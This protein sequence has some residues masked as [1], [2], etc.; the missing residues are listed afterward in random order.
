MFRGWARAAVVGLACVGGAWIVHAQDDA[1]VQSCA[2]GPRPTDPNETAFQGVGE[3]ERLSW[4]ADR[5]PVSDD[6]LRAAAAAWAGAPLEIRTVRCAGLAMEGAFR[7]A[8]YPYTRVSA[9]PQRVEAGLVRFQVVEGWV[10][11]VTPA[12]DNAR[13]RLQAHRRLRSLEAGDEPRALPLREVERAAAL[14]DTAPGLVARMAVTRGGEDRAGAIR[15][16]AEAEP[17]PRNIVVNL[18]NFGADE[19]GRTGASILFSTPGRAPLG[20]RLTLSFY[21][22]L[23]L[24]EQRAARIT[25]QRGLTASGLVAGLE[26]AYGQAEPSGEVRVLGAAAESLSG[27]FELT[28]PVRLG[29]TTRLQAGMGVDGADQSG[30]LFGGEVRLSEDSTRNVFARLWGEAAPGCARFTSAPRG[31]CWRLAGEIEARQ[32]LDGL[33]AS[34]EGDELLARPFADPQAHVLRAA[35]DAET[36]SGPLDVRARLQIS[37]QASSAALMA[38]EEFN[39]GNYTLVRGYDPGAVAGDSGIAG[40]LELIGPTLRVRR[41]GFEPFGFYDLGKVWNE[42]PGAPDGRTLASVG[43]GMRMNLDRGVRFEATWSR[44]LHPPL[45]LGESQPS[46]RVLFSLTTSVTSLLRQAT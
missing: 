23:D 7:D 21:T 2:A 31:A 39:F 37:G 28:H 13:A 30:D 12:G 46:S 38:F 45:G 43:A 3:I 10:E 42:D 8:G 16:V 5:S 4:A 11:R 22:T 26:L 36:P 34:Y 25:Y 24:E 20:D 9:P 27:R 14:L 32:G 35:I 18:N 40:A 17:E 44:P 41:V 33:G 15:I 6:A 19:L 29:R 1:D